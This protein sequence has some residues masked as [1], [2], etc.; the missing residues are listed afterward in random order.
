MKCTRHNRSPRISVHDLRMNQRGLCELDA[1]TD[2]CW[3]TGVRRHSDTRKDFSDSIARP[4]H[5]L[6]LTDKPSAVL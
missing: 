6:E 1:F 2:V 3:L 5:N 4:Q